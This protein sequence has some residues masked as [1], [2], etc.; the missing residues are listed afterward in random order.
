[1]NKTPHIKNKNK[2]DISTLSKAKILV[3]EDNAINQEIITGLLQHSS[4]EIDFANNGKEAIE[5]F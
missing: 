1:M 3:V 2:F 5:R 4:I